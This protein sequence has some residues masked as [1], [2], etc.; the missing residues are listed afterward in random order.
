MEY[1][2]LLIKKNKQSICMVFYST[3]QLTLKANIIIIFVLH[4]VLIN[5]QIMHQQNQKCCTQPAVPNTPYFAIFAVGLLSQAIVFLVAYVSAVTVLTNT[6]VVH[7]NL[8]KLCRTMK[9]MLPLNIQNARNTLKIIVSFTVKT[10]TF[11]SVIRA[12]HQ[13]N[14][15]DTRSQAI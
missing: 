14:I 11:L 12:F 15:D 10:V 13:Q 6:L 3:F 4:I 1:F 7:P 2:F 5:W 8:T 9:N